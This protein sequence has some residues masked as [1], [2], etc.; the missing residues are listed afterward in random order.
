M[1]EERDELKPEAAAPKGDPAT[2]E[3]QESAEGGL[4]EELEGEEVRQLVEQAQAGD[5]EA[6]NDLFTRYYGKMVE[7]ARRR[8]GP[9]LRSKEEA[10]DLAQ[11][12]FREATRDFGAY[13]YR[14]E[15][16][17][18]RWLMQILRNKICDKA[19]YYS[20]TKRDVTRERSV[21][22]DTSDREGF[23]GFEPPSDDLSVTRQV[24][25]EEEFAIL[26]EALKDLSD[27]H[28]T[29][30]ALVFF[31]GLSLR[32]AGERMGGRSEDAVRMLLRR[33]EGRM[34]ELTKSRFSQ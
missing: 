29:A 27:D 10:D 26:R 7:L 14:G 4:P 22:G 33:A 19:V 31:R 11:T 25:R 1:T 2:P 12:T 13:E 8:L 6:L 30:I 20:A 24:Q 17:L 23:S 21:D 18:L 28:R 34:R 9:K 15:S 32:E 5:A 16:S 3:R